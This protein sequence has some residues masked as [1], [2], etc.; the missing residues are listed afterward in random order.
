MKTMIANGDVKS[1]VFFATVVINFSDSLILECPPV[2][3]GGVV[4]VKTYFPENKY[5]LKNGESTLFYYRNEEL[6]GNCQLN[7]GNICQNEHNDKNI[8]LQQNFTAGLYN[9]TITSSSNTTW[10]KTSNGTLFHEVWNVRLEDTEINKTCDIQLYAIYDKLNC[11][12]N[13]AQDLNITCFLHVFPK[14]LCEFNITLNNFLNVT[15]SVVYDHELVKDAYNT[16]CTFTPHSMPENGTLDISVAMYPNITGKTGDRSYGKNI[17]FYYPELKTTSTT[18]ILTS[19]ATSIST[20]QTIER[21]SSKEKELVLIITASSIGLLILT[22]T[23]VIVII[24]IVKRRGE[25]LEESNSCTYCWY[26]SLYR[27]QFLRQ[28]VTEIDNTEIFSLTLPKPKL[29]AYSNVAKLQ[30]SDIQINANKFNAGYVNCTKVAGLRMLM[31]TIY[32]KC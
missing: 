18:Y 1:L 31:E 28:K 7:A 26:T 9:S 8:N 12:I 2:K 10:R 27:R 22:T 17:Q 5:Q 6:I 16:S 29:D 23:A 24:L 15:G 14:G 32:Y 21:I 11:S 13:S 3:E 4:I 25:N 20:N 19:K 30:L